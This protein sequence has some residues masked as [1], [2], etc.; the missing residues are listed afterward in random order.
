MTTP[1]VFEVD[2]AINAHLA[3]ALQ[4]ARSRTLALFHGI[5]G[6]RLLGP[7]LSIVNPP[8][9][10]LGHLGWFQEYWCLRRCGDQSCAPALL[11]NADA[12]YDSTRVAHA[13]RWDL[14]LLSLDKTLAYLEEVLERVLER[15]AHGAPIGY[16][17]ELAL[18]HEDMHDEAFLYTRQ[19]LG[20]ETPFSA[21]IEPPP[22]S[23]GCDIA[24]DGG[25][26]M[27][28][29]S[30]DGRFVFDNEKW[31]HPVFV[32]P[33]RIARDA[34][35]NREFLDFVEDG[36]YANRE[37]W[38]VEGWQWRS[39]RGSRHPVYW[40]RAD[41]QWLE[42]RFDQWQVLNLTAPVLHVNWY[43]ARAYCNWTKRRLPSEAEW[44]F[45]AAAAPGLGAK[46]DYSWGSAAPSRARANLDL[47]Y[48]G[49]VPVASL[50]DG[51]S[52]WGV[53]QMIGNVW[54]WTNDSFGPY[55]GFVADPYQE[56][57]QPWFTGH[58][59]LRGGCFAT[60]ARLI[61][62]SWRNFYTPERND[63]FAGFRTCALDD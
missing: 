43:E 24:I 52:A 29:A 56:Y 34:V 14:P 15:L 3:A 7:R 18:Y 35:S 12:L 39:S 63:V 38:D 27:L 51:D 2:P 5:D 28:G 21:R 26:F 10:E 19:T 11:P 57:S 58:K 41:E 30:D 13:T 1:A 55:P 9:W 16:F 23:A 46:R 4:D 37:L 48:G 40:R 32:A 17:A 49:T 61:R 47:W 59:V 8:L 33:F 6:E 45:A 31:A 50:P 44:E 53:R 36:G 54:E 22:G 25:P 20:Y 62:N 60:R 42:R